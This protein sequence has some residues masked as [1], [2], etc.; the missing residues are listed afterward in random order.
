MKQPQP[1]RET[2]SPEERNFRDPGT[3]DELRGTNL[4][5][6]VEYGEGLA[7]ALTFITGIFDNAQELVVIFLGHR[8]P[9]LGEFPHGSCVFLGR[10][11]VFRE[12]SLVLGIGGIGGLIYGHTAQ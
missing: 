12:Q 4:V 2:K 9:V 5:P 6:Q 8:R 10:G 3:R 1:E 11:M 7:Y